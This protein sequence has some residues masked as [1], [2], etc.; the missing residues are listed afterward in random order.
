M[1]SVCP[2]APRRSR[3]YRVARRSL[4]SSQNA[5][6]GLFL[7][8]EHAVNCRH[9]HTH[10]HTYITMWHCTV[11]LRLNP[12]NYTGINIC[13]TCINVPGTSLSQHPVS[14]HLFWICCKGDG[15]CSLWGRKLCPGRKYTNSGTARGTS[16]QGSFLSD[17][18]EKSIKTAVNNE[19]K[20]LIFICTRRYT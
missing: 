16:K 17:I 13:T 5:A 4:P 6:T 8:R 11:H 12:Q 2:Q 20:K 15:M 9:T 7:F 1:S 3:G 18:E 19:T 10:T 14:E